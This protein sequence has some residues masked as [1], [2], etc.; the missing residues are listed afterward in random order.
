MIIKDQNNLPNMSKQFSKTS[1]GYIFKLIDANKNHLLKVGRLILTDMTLI[2][3]S[4]IKC[5]NNCWFEG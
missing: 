2:E 5:S 4:R 3:L 1:K